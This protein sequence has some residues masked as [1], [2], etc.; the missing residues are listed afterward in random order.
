MLCLSGPQETC[1]PITPPLSKTFSDEKGETRAPLSIN[2][3]ARRRLSQK[4]V[5][6]LD[7]A[8]VRVGSET[9][10]NIVRVGDD[11]PKPC[12]TNP[13]SFRELH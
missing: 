10:K 11:G 7:V 12:L 4:D 1:D 5:P 6:R 2:C 9:R 8:V 13:E 3:E